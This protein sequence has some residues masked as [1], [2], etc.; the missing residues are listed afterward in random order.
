MDNAQI[1]RL[2]KTAE[3][4]R[5]C[6]QKIKLLSEQIDNIKVS[7]VVRFSTPQN[8]EKLAQI[9]DGC[10]SFNMIRGAALGVLEEQL[11][12]ERKFLSEYPATYVEK[13]GRP[14]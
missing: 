3:I 11:T 1:E 9:E 7:R 10:E 2:K 6:E 13:G 14:C 5:K 12:Q 4:V 8:V